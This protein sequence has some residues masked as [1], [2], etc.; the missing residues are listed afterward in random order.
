MSTACRIVGTSLRKDESR[1]ASRV[2]L[3]ERLACHEAYISQM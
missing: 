1:V 2:D 3:Q